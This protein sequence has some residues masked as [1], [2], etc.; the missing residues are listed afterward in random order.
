MIILLSF[1]FKKYFHNKNMM[2]QFFV[3]PSLL[4][5][6]ISYLLISYFDSY[7]LAVYH[8]FFPVM[9][10]MYL[11]YGVNAAFSLLDI[12]NIK[13]NKRL[14]YLP[15]KQEWVVISHVFS[16]TLFGSITLAVN[17]LIFY[18]VLIQHCSNLLGS[19]FII[20][21]MIFLSNMIG[22]F[23]T[24]FS[25]NII[26]IEEI[27]TLFQIIFTVLGGVFFRLDYYSNIPSIIIMCS[28]LKWI[29]DAIYSYI[30]SGSADSLIKVG[31]GQLVISILLYLI[32]H[33]KFNAYEF[34]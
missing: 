4:I 10:I 25:K 14:F 16:Q 8:Y 7:S 27:F 20:V 5:L 9:L 19:Y 33:K 17:Y 34:C 1:Q 15:V 11:G 21:G 29:S 6:L 22:I 12:N 31:C 13:G 23:L 3:L 28:P 32:I 30:E 2:F 26:L 24:L 18:F